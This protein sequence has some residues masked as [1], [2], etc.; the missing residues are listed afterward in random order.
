MLMQAK[1]RTRKMQHARETQKRAFAI[2]DRDQ[3]KRC[4]LRAID[5]LARL[6]ASAFALRPEK[7]R[8][9]CNHFLALATI[10][11]RILKPNSGNHVKNAFPA[12]RARFSVGH[13]QSEMISNDCTP[14][15]TQHVAAGPSKS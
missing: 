9:K 4:I 8:T 13:K 12:E 2:V 14:A 7:D 11:S 10:T 15:E 5:T 3:Q 6:L 1:V